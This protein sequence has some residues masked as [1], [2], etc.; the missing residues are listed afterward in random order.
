MLLTKRSKCV[1]EYLRNKQKGVKHET[2]E[3]NTQE[4]NVEEPIVIK[5]DLP[6]IVD[7]KTKNKKKVKNN[8]NENDLNNE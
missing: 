2:P 5:N 7:D 6:E 4:I 3:V 8:L 1:Q